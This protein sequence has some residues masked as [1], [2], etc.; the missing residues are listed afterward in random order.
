MNSRCP[1][2][3]KPVNLNPDNNWRPFCSNRCR[4]IDLGAWFDGNR[5]IP[6]EEVD[7]QYPQDEGSP[8]KH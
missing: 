2:C 8:V 3:E 4:L 1:A 7:Y 6:D 5:L